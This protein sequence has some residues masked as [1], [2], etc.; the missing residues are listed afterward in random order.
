[1]QSP[2]HFFLSFVIELGGRLW[3]VTEAQRE[4]GQR[5]GSEKGGDLLNVAQ[6]IQAGQERTDG[7]RL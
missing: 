3:T 6:T 1:M 5:G 2:R 7:E 4:K